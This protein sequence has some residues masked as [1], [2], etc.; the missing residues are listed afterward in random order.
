MRVVPQ[1]SVLK[2]ISRQ[3][4]ASRTANPQNAMLRT[5]LVPAKGNDLFIK[6]VITA[7]KQLVTGS[8]SWPELLSNTC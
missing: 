1:T 4:N 6:V 7:M 8:F 3:G 2:S 5:Q